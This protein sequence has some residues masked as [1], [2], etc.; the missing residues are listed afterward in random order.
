MMLP[1][2]LTGM[3]SFFSGG[4]G[5]WL[6]KN[7]GLRLG[8]VDIPNDRSSHTD[9]VPKG[10]G[11][12]ILAAFVFCSL[13][14]QIP[15]F[16]WGPALMLSIVSLAGDKWEVSPG[17]RLVIQF[18][19]G[20]LFLA[21]FV[22]T[23]RPDAVMYGLL[24][25][26]VL[27]MAGTANYY[28]FMDGINGIAAVTGIVAFGLLTIYGIVTG[29]EP[30]LIVL[31]FSI[32]CACAGFLPFNMP[33]ARVFMGDVGS[34][35]L[36]FVFAGLVI[37]WAT[38]FSAFILLAS[39]LFPFYADELITTGER[40]RD[41]ERLTRAHRRHFYQVL[42]NEGA[43][44]HWLVAVGYGGVQLLVGIAVWNIGEEYWPVRLGVLAIF[45]VIFLV[46]N[47]VVKRRLGM[48]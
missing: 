22:H 39:F 5:A 17:Y 20:L 8:M 21:V 34:I 45:L 6:I 7:Y 2:G 31:S 27:F 43:L 10:G 48:I 18:L 3:L 44:P 1:Y 19:A 32:M 23:I 14:F 12:G 26:L 46:A 37:W 29:K 4:V 42:V 36:G 41:G 40:L 9:I 28:N 38:S 33:T 30:A 35:L 25:P 11:I 15:A 24:F 16:F 13:L 47:I